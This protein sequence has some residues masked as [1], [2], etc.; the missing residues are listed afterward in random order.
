MV[1][2]VRQWGK[3]VLTGG[4]MLLCSFF[5]PISL[6][7]KPNQVLQTLQKAANKL[8]K[9]ST[10]PIPLVDD[11]PVNPHKERKD[12]SEQKPDKKKKQKP[13]KNPFKK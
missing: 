1:Q 2:Q 13:P 5:M 4:V 11:S 12:S 7:A 8:N 10:A 9:D 3:I 6:D